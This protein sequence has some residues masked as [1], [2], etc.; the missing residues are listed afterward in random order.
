MAFNEPLRLGLVCG[1][2]GGVP[3]GH[4]GGRQFQQHLVRGSVPEVGEGKPR[5]VGGLICLKAEP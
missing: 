1:N 5:L 4:L 3:A 2:V